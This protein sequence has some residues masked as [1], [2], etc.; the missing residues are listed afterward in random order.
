MSSRILSSTFSI[1][2]HTIFDSCPEGNG[3]GATAITRDSKYLATISDAE[4]QEVCIWRW[5]S[6]VE[7]PACTLNLLKEYGVQ[8]LPLSTFSC[9][10]AV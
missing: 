4:I 10:V 5:T 7:T 3:I 9:C 8:V 1:P 2:V 6:A